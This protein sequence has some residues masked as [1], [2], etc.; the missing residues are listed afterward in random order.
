M[1]AEIE[2]RLF[3][4]G[5]DKK[6]KNP[7]YTNSLDSNYFRSAG[8]V[9]AASLAQGGPCPNLMR[10]WCFRYL[11]S[12]DSD[13]IQVSVSDVTDFKLLQL[14]ERV[15]TTLTN[16][17]NDNI[18]D[19]VDDIVT[20]GFTGIVSMEKRDIMIRT[21]VLHSTMRVIP[22]LDQLRKGLQLYDLPKIMKTHQD[23][24]LPLLVPG[25]GNEADAAFLLESSRPVFSEIGSAKHQRKTTFRKLR[26]LEI[27]DRA[28]RRERIFQDHVDLF[29]ESDEYLFGR[30]RLPR[31]VLIDLC[32]YLEPALRSHTHRSNPVP[33][34][35]QVLST[36][37][38][39]ATGS[40]QRELGDRV[41]ISQ[42]SISRA[43]PRVVDAINQLATEYIQ[44]PYTAE[45]QVT[46]KRGFHLIAG[47][48]NTIGAID[49][50]HVRI[51]APSPDSFPYLNRKQYHSINVQ[52]ICD[53]NN[54]LLNVSRFPGGAHDSYIFQNSSVGT[55]LE[56][57]AADDS[58]VIGDRGYALAPWLMTPLTN[59]Q[60][61][62]EVSYNQMHARTRSTIELV[63]DFLV[64]LRELSRSFELVRSRTTHH[65][66]ER[67]IGILKGR[68]MCLDTA[69]GKL[70]YKPEKV[71]R[72]IMAC[73][74][75]HNI[76]MKREQ[77]GPSNNSVTAEGLTV[78]RVMQ[79]MTGQ[80]H[81]PVLSE[82]KDFDK[83]E[84]TP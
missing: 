44:C 16:A 22:M 72:I 8:E 67:T 31:A 77:E 61:P 6:R 9:M 49:C 17:S 82:K 3:V 14:I 32:N 69:G 27:A 39:L 30:F 78:G 37:R 70:L 40:F 4:G 18:S 42:P 71:C 46:V 76:A 15:N 56:Q 12:G 58:W 24:C 84:I 66:I 55:R 68:W 38:F 35:V 60:T 75:L 29:S 73:C 47:L 51:K 21:V 10:E 1:L 50:T 63:V 64:R 5:S 54:H 41:G 65:Y 25:E 11:C 52:L 34:H 59:P 83:H 23:L 7:V 36:L 74:V 81:R 13:S 26:I 53:S 19:L 62:R 45:E 79:W 2:N 20:C 80:R 43:L 33:P 57:V 28:L 48:P